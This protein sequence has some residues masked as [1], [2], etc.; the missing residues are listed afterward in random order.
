MVTYISWLTRKVYSSVMTFC[1]F[2]WGHWVSHSFLYCP[3]YTHPFPS[4]LIH[5][6]IWLEI[7]SLMAF[8]LTMLSVN[9]DQPFAS[10]HPAH[11]NRTWHVCTHDCMHTN[12]LAKTV[13]PEIINI[14][15]PNFEDHL[16]DNPLLCLLKFN[17]PDCYS[18]FE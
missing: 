6:G 9:T 10:W 14:C 8:H 16:L 17:L 2:S 11:Q 7:L 5:T 13:K 3:L 15:L 1:V 12:T 4:V 18:W